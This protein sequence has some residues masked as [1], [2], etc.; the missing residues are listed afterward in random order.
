MDI[1]LFGKPEIAFNGEVEAEFCDKKVFRSGVSYVYDTLCGHRICINDVKFHGERYV[2]LY[3]DRRLI[4]EYN[5]HAEKHKERYMSDPAFFDSRTGFL[6]RAVPHSI[7]GGVFAA[8]VAAMLFTV[9]NFSQTLTGVVVSFAVL[10]P[11]LCALIFVATGMLYTRERRKMAKYA[12]ISSLKKR[13]R[14][15]KKVFIRLK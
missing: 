8:F 10:C 13:R 9:M 11:L 12:I 3:I 14:R 4:K 15:R 2:S 5:V 1:G 7:L 6:R